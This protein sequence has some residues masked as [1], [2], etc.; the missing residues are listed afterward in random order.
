MSSGFELL[1]KDFILAYFGFQVSP[2]AGPGQI[3]VL[4]ETEQEGA[5]HRSDGA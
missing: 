2:V 3:R 5:T 4:P 1:I